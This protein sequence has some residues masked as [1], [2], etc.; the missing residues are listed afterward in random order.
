M[1]PSAAEALLRLIELAK[2]VSD[3]RATLAMLVAAEAAVLEIGRKLDV[4]LADGE[5]GGAL[6]A[7]LE[8]EAERLATARQAL[9]DQAP[10]ISRLLDSGEKSPSESSAAAR[11]KASA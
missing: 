4:A 1:T 6:L 2:I 11:A 9:S 10:A 7:E 5:D 8:R 3:V